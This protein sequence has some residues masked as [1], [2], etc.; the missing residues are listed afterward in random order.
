M[1]LD[2]HIK[3]FTYFG[4]VP[5]RMAHDN[6]KAVVDTIFVGKVRQFNR[7]FLTLAMGT[8]IR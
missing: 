2:A 3:A 7:R 4:G 8:G 6:L 1:V 5:K